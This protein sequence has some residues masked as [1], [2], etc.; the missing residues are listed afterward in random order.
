MALQVGP[1]QNEETAMADMTRASNR[2]ELLKNRADFEKVNAVL[3]LG[4]E[5]EKE[6][7][8]KAIVF[9]KRAR[10]HLPEVFE[11]HYALAKILMKS[12]AEAGETIIAVW[13][14][15]L[16]LGLKKTPVDRENIAYIY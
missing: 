16:G 5:L 9:F 2:A 14:A 3:D 15:A 10:L 13:C 12:T 11:F 8:K 4:E 1:F 6:D 7:L